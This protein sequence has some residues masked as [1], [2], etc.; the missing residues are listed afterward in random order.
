MP[1]G[2]SAT[3]SPRCLGPLPRSRCSKGSPPGLA[4]PAGGRRSRR[5]SAARSTRAC[6]SAW[7]R[8]RRGRASP[9]RSAGRAAGQQVRREGVPQRVRA[10]LGGSPALPRGAGR[11]VEARRVRRPPRWLT[12]RRRLVAAP[13]AAAGRGRGRRRAPRPRRADGTMR[14]LAPLPRAR[15]TPRSRSRSPTVEP[16]RLRRAQ[17]ARVHQLEQRPVAQGGRRRSRRGCP[18]QR[19]DLVEREHLGQAWLCAAARRS[20]SGSW[21]MRSSRRRWR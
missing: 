20:R 18:E 4:A 7:S 5:P 12:N 8:C 3:R 19:R 16:D 15:R 14:S 2:V 11:S 17:A 13:I 10:H 9:A 1:R 21:S 6:R